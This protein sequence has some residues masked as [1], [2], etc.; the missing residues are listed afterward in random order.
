MC[1]KEKIGAVV[2]KVDLVR[3]EE[4]N[5][6]S[7]KGILLCHF[8][9]HRPITKAFLKVKSKEIIPKYFFIDFVLILE[10]TSYVIHIFYGK[11][12]KIQNGNVWF[13][14]LQFLLRARLYLFV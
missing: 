3:K 7:M 2:D 11:V 10:R 1:T 4:K 12:K 14:R 9:K 8:S 6:F 5:T 13:H